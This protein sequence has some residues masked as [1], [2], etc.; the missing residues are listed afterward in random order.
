MALCKRCLAFEPA[1][2]PADAG[3]VAQAVAGLRA[4]ADE[5]AR[6]AELERVR[7]EGEQATAAA[8][9][10]ERR[11]RR[12][13][14]IGAAAVLAVAALGGLTAVLAVQRRANAD[15][16]AKNA[17]LA[18]EQAKVEVARSTAVKEAAA[19]TA[20][21]RDLAL[22]LADSYTTLGLVA[23][24]RN[25]PAAAA[26]WFA[27]AVRQSEG[28]PERELHNRVR[29]RNWAAETFTPVAAIQ[30]TS[31]VT[32]L[33]LHPG[34]RYLATRSGARH[35]SVWELDREAPWVPPT[36]FDTLTA[37]SWNADGSRIALAASDKAGTARVGVF[38][39]PSGKVVR[40]REWDGPVSV[41]R[42]SPD[43]RTL[44]IGGRVVLVWNP[45]DDQLMTPALP[46]PSPVLAIEFAPD[47]KR[48]VTQSGVGPGAD[49]RAARPACLT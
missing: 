11:K 18:V 30:P 4:A 2:R 44:A 24:E 28:D 42:F 32:E 12:R 20:A 21:R 37:L 8:R 1:D 45:D 39:F 16:A 49:H 47:G 6:R 22:T 43:G 19:A 38:E 17:A 5:R 23:G 14:V 33:A 41:V 25:D 35:Y 15:L 3:A 48:L 46:H 7:V 13:L 34:G 9:A 40:E 27:R 26:L 10:A 29:Y 36:G 31:R